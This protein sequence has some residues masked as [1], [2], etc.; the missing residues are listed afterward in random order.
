MAD[1][2]PEDGTKKAVAKKAAAKTSAAKKSAAKKAPAKKAA[3]KKAAAKKAATKKAPAK[4]AASKKAPAKKAASKKAAAKKGSAGKTP[5]RRSALEAGY[6]EGT[7]GRKL[8]GGP[9][10]TVTERRNLSITQVAAF[11]DTADKTRATIEKIVGVAPP[12]N[13]VS[14]VVKGKTHI[15]WNGPNR[16]WIVESDARDVAPALKKALGDD[17]AVVTLG[18]SRTCLRVSGTSL[19]DVMSKGSTYDYHPSAFKPGDCIQTGMAHVGV[20]LHCLGDKNGAAEVDIYILRSFALH[21]FE[22]LQESAGEY[23][24]RVEPMVEA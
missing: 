20:S 16:W 22:W 1:E 24:Y 23:G 12:Q 3:T 2:T 11:D 14:G 17:A 19:R 6:K 4:K 13:A 8:P 7:F 9:G 21:F 15:L 10:I 5:S 18:H